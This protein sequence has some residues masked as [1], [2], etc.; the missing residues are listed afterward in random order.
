MSD[1]ER[2]ARCDVQP[3]LSLIDQLR[4]AMAA[5]SSKWPDQASQ[6]ALIDARA[7]ID[8]AVTCLLD[9]GPPRGSDRD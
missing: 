4:D 9:V 3:A 1:L 6:E 5:I 7:Y 8:Q 2:Q